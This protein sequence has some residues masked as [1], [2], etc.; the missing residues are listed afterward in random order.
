MKSAKKK[1]GHHDDHMDAVQKTDIGFVFIFSHVKSES[2]L[3]PM[4]AQN[5]DTD[6]VIYKVS[7][8][9]CG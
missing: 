7:G 6:L 9:M 3:W 2:K 8:F 5:S 4:T 1:K